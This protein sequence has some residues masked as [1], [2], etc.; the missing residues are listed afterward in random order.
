MSEARKEALMLICTRDGLCSIIF[1][2]GYISVALLTK[3][4]KMYPLNINK[5]QEQCSQQLKSDVS[6]K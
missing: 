4:V 1:F 5:I 6:C 2:N 3:A